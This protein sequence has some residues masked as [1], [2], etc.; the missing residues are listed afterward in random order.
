LAEVVA[1]KKPAF[2]R[3]NLHIGDDTF[4]VYVPLTQSAESVYQF[5]GIMSIETDAINVAEFTF[6][7]NDGTWDASG[8]Y[9]VIT[10]A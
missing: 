8:R 5:V 6:A 7:D 9:I 4:H 3:L 2:L 1:A 10:S